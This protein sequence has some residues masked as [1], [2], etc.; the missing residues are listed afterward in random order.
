MTEYSLFNSADDCL[1]YSIQESIFDKSG[2][3]NV[4]FQEQLLFCTRHTS[5]TLHCSPAMWNALRWEL[6]P[7]CRANRQPVRVIVPAFRDLENADDGS[8]AKTS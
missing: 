6:H 5:S 7:C 1:A 4:L 3:L 2:M 8:G